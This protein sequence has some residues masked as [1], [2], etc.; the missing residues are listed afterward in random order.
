MN[1]FST[2][3]AYDDWRRKI[4]TKEMLRP[5]IDTQEEKNVR[6]LPEQSYN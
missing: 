2:L 4:F 3:G 1:E 5:T 6:S